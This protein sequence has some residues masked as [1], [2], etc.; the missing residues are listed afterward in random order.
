MCKMSHS[1]EVTVWHLVVLKKI[2]KKT[3]WAIIPLSYTLC[4]L[5]KGQKERAYLNVLNVQSQN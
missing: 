5:M 4:I 1:Q 2:T 3:V